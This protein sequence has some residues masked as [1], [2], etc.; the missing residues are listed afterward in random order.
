MRQV[1]KADKITGSLS[2]GNNGRF[3]QSRLNGDFATVVD[4]GLMPMLRKRGT[5]HQ[6][7]NCTATLDRNVNPDIT[8]IGMPG[9]RGLQRG[10]GEVWQEVEFL[11]YGQQIQGRSFQFRQPGQPCLR[12]TAIIA[13]EFGVTDTFC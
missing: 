4:R 10:N 11:R 8:D 9:W 3:D 13:L 5:L 1:G 6:H 7:A 2:F 12:K